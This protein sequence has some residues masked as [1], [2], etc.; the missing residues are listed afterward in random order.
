MGKPSAGQRTTIKFANS[1][2]AFSQIKYS[3]YKKCCCCLKKKDVKDILTPTQQLHL[4]GYTRIRE[5]LNL[6]SIIKSLFKLKAGL[7]AVIGDDKQLSDKAKK[8]Y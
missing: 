8:L 3:I 5:E 1:L 6:M 7:S 4:K 2:D